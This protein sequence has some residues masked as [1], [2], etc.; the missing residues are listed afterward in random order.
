MK[1]IIMCMLLLAVT[2]I[3]YHPVEAA[4]LSIT[5]PD[6][7]ATRVNNAVATRYDYLIKYCDEN[8]Q[9]CSKSKGAFTKE[10]VS[11]FIKDIVKS[12]ELIDYIATQKSTKSAKLD[13][14]F[15]GVN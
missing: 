6:A 5:V 14:D 1:K 2:P 10:V 13:S 15:S 4:T 7:L 9:N 12:Q 3:D 8:G 11:D